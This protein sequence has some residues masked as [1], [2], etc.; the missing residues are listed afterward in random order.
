MLLRDMQASSK[1][2]LTGCGLVLFAALS[3]STAGVGVKLVD[4]PPATIAG[5][6][7]LSA[8]PVLLFA[9]WH[10]DPGLRLSTAFSG[11]L[12]KPL[13]LF[14]ALTYALCV[15]LFVFATKLTTA[16]NATLFQYSAPIYTAL[17]SWPILRESI[18]LPDWVAL[19]GCLGGI[20]LCFGGSL[21]GTGWLGNVL[22]LLSGLCFGLLPLLWRRMTR[23]E[24]SS[25]S[26]TVVP[27][28]DLPMLSLVFGNLLIVLGA[29]PSMVSHPPATGVQVASL[30]VMGTLQIGAAYLAYVAAVK[31]LR[32]IECLLIATLEPILNPVWVALWANETPG[33]QTLLGGGVI[34]GSVLLRAAWRRS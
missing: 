31:R 16:A 18:R 32:A 17:L 24:P 1:R 15:S 9:L 12:R 5:Y 29:A 23:N 21:S 33:A 27:A 2:R 3:W 11:A 8:L 7:A 28:A 14:T 25:P 30:A 4:L 20:V 6:R 34:I 19:L 26:T 13:L 22:A 10:G